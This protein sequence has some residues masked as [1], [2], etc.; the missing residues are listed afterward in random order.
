MTPSGN[1]ILFHRGEA[2]LSALYPLARLAKAR[3]L[4]DRNEYEKFFDLWK[5]ADPD[6]PALQA[7]RKEFEE[8]N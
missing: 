5:D 4:K 7:A 1:S 2:P 8:L 6:M 3:A